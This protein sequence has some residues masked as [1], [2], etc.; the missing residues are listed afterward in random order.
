ME[1]G[2]SGIILPPILFLPNMHRGTQT[3]IHKH[4]HTF[5]VLSNEHSLH[6]CYIPGILHLWTFI[7][8][9]IFTERETSREVKKPLHSSPRKGCCRDLNPDSLVSESRLITMML[10]DKRFLKVTLVN[11]SLKY[12]F[13]PESSCSKSIYL[14]CLKLSK[15]KPYI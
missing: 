1:K 3:Y 13:S 7:F 12:D 15:N 8:N 6:T 2:F 14:L 11:F 10:L 9:T 5:T 4:S